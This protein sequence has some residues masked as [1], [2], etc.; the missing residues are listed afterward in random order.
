MENKE[1][2]INAKSAEHKRVISAQAEVWEGS[3]GTVSEI[4]S[5]FD[6]KKKA[7]EIK[8]P[9]NAGKATPTKSKVAEMQHKIVTHVARPELSSTPTRSINIPL[10]KVIEMKQ[11]ITEVG[12][13]TKSGTYTPTRSINIPMNKVNEIRKLLASLEKGGRDNH[14]VTLSSK[15]RAVIDAR[16]NTVSDIMKWIEEMSKHNQQN[17][18]PSSK[19]GIDLP[20]NRVNEMKSWLLDFERHNKEHFIEGSN[21]TGMPKTEKNHVFKAPTE[22]P[23]NV[24]KDITFD[25]KS[26]DEEKQ[27]SNDITHPDVLKMISL[28]NELDRKNRATN[29]KPG[30]KKMD[31]YQYAVKQDQAKPVAIENDAIDQKEDFAENENNSDDNVE[32]PIT[33]AEVIHEIETVENTPY[34]EE[35][36]DVDISMLPRHPDDSFGDES[37][38][39][40]D[41]FAELSLSNDDEGS[42]DEFEENQNGAEVRKLLDSFINCDGSKDYDTEESS[43]RLDYSEQDSHEHS[44]NHLHMANVELDSG[45]QANEE[46]VL[47]QSTGPLLSPGCKFEADFDQAFFQ[48]EPNV[49]KLPS[50][51]QPF[52]LMLVEETTSSIANE[53][54][55]MEQTPEA[56]IE[57]KIKALVPWR[58]HKKII[59]E[60]RTS[61]VN[62]KLKS[63]KVGHMLMKVLKRMIRR[64]GDYKLERNK[65]HAIPLARTLSESEAASSAISPLSRLSDY[66]LSPR[67]PPTNEIEGDGYLPIAYVGKTENNADIVPFKGPLT[68][69]QSL[70]SA[71]DNQLSPDSSEGS[72]ASDYALVLAKSINVTQHVQFMRG[73]FGSPTQRLPNKSGVVIGELSLVASSGEI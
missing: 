70:A 12:E 59:I 51:D 9:P 36:Q 18:H 2:E 38:D 35:Q 3:N 43:I 29:I 31:K 11:K 73:V 58:A 8:V 72:S 54:R 22:L 32:I 67:V 24:Q 61:H 55:V 34:H 14:D 39:W 17:N 71:F 21:K 20:V 30:V 23:T 47:S 60:T 5:K 45:N 44:N 49:K 63:R 62:K 57:S 27:I 68:P 1:N 10:N 28:L 46:A 69:D 26:S 64:S 37:D 66:N 52:S 50:S 56:P 65:Q 42:I 15:K 19:R 4:K 25:N 13:K 41:V 6:A 7:T 40:D 33:E 16:M 53:H 48:S